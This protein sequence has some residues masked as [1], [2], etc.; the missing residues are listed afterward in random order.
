MI[1]MHELDSR[2]YR[3]FIHLTLPVVTMHSSLLFHAQ[4]SQGPNGEPQDAYDLT[5]KAFILKSLFKM[6]DLYFTTFVP[7][8]PTPC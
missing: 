7:N 5:E 8:N 2:A 4:T 6:Q 1:R 3:F